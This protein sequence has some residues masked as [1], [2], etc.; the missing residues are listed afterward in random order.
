[1]LGIPDFAGGFPDTSAIDAALN[2]HLHIRGVSKDKG[3]LFSHSKIVYVDRKL[4]YVGSDNAYPCYN[5]EHGVWVEDG[6]T[7]GN[8][9]KDFFTSYWARC[10]EPTGEK[11]HFKKLKDKGGEGTKYE[12]WSGRWKV[13]LWRMDN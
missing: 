8:W 1:M 7:V 4:M 11:E 6:T 13:K 5:E 9:L 10:T 12:G 2:T 3:H